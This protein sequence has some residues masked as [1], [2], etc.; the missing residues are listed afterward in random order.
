MV[1]SKHKNPLGKECQ[2]LLMKEAK[3]FKV[4]KRKRIIN[5]KPS[6]LVDQF[7]SYLRNGGTSS[8]PNLKSLE[9]SFVPISNQRCRKDMLPK[10]ELLLKTLP[11][12][13]G[14]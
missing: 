1:G 8:M 11:Q 3:D 2:Q 14:N 12:F 10:L 7:Q 9:I 5:K 4:P 13:T 6:W